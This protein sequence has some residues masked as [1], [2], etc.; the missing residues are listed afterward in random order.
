MADS[1]F[2]VLLIEGKRAEYPAFFSGLKTK[3][4][5]VELES[6]GSDGLDRIDELDPHVVIVNAPSMRTT[7]RRICKS[8]HQAKPKL[9]VVLVVEEGT[10]VKNQY[11]AEVV[12]ELPFTLQK[13]INRIKVLAPPEDNNLLVAGPIQLDVENNWVRCHDKHT[14]L[15][16]RLVELLRA[17]MEQ[18]GE[19]IERTELF[20]RVWETTYTGDTRTM[21]VH[22]SWLRQA[23]EENP[24]HPEYIKTVRGVGYRLDI[25]QE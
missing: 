22:I 2:R 8:I 25:G 12:L 10:R 5:Q 16:P 15:T 6:S 24:R 1:E 4:Y 23:I 14:S 21:D 20:S 3:G 13:L 11:E 19:I 9:P 17:L 18:P 7:G